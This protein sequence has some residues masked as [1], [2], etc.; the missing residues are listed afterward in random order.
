LA[1]ARRHLSGFGHDDEDG[2]SEVDDDAV[3]RPS[4]IS[5]FST[6]AEYDDPSPVQSPQ[7]QRVSPAVR[8][9]H[10]SR[11]LRNRRQQ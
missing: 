4:T 5:H 2:M 1:V 6:S 9:L 8:H 3:R 11:V 7:S 10:Q